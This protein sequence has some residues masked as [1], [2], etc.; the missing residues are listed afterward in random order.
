MA[1]EKVTSHLLQWRSADAKSALL[2]R[3]GYTLENSHR[4][5]DDIREQLLSIEAE[6]IDQTEYGP[7]YMIRGAIT[8]P[9]GDVLRVA[10][11][12]MTEEGTGK[13]KFITL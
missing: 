10:T 12:W 1:T 13:T 11:I 7:K 2:A 4:L 3:A 5:L 8:G 9:N 6:L